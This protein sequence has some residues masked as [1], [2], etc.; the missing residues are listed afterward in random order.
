[1]RL[2]RTLGGLI[3]KTET[4]IQNVINWLSKDD[5]DDPVDDLP[6]IENNRAF[7]EALFWVLKPSAVLTST[8]HSDGKRQCEDC[9]QEESLCRC[10]IPQ[11]LEQHFSRL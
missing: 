10:H 1:V 8:M 7:R 2:I 11:D 4:E 5:A 6:Y 3:L 9:G